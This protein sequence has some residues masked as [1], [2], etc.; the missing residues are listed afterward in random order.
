MNTDK[1]KCIVTLQ[2]YQKKVFLLA[3]EHM[4]GEFKL[5]LQPVLEKRA[6]LDHICRAM[7]VEIGMHQPDSPDYAEKNLDKACGHLYRSFF[8]AAEWMGIIIRERMQ[9][10]YSDY[11]NA[12]IST[13][14]PKYYK[15]ISPGVEKFNTNVANIRNEKDFNKSENPLKLVDQVKE[16][17]EQIEC[18]L[19]Y[20]EVMSTSIPSIEEYRERRKKEQKK[21]FTV[22]IVKGVV[23]GLIIAAVIAVIAYVFTKN[24][25]PQ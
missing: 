24:N 15:E 6:A 8:D 10:L 21:Q 13:I 2:Q 14:L 12:C 18:L 1:W 19:G 3:E 23:I 17:M 22:D 11:D 9:R 20:F 5:F 4:F 25:M 16:Y 7:S